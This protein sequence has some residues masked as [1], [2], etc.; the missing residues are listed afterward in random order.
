M[1]KNDPN[2]IVD[3]ERAA[4]EEQEP[5]IMT[6]MRDVVDL[7][8]TGGGEVEEVILHLFNIATEDEQYPLYEIAKL[9]KFELPHIPEA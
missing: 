7:Y 1:K 8:D 3:K 4:I 9:C 5:S 6:A 2:S